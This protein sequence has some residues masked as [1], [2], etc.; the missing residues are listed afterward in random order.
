MMQTLDPPIVIETRPECDASV[1]WLHGLGADGNDFAPVVP[2]LGLAPDLAVRFVFPH[3]PRRPVT[4]NGGMVMRAWFDMIP[5]RTGFRENEDDLRTSMGFVD[6]LVEAERVRGVSP[7]RIVLAG[8]SQGALTALYTALYLPVELAGVLALSAWL[9]EGGELPVPPYALPVFL[10]HGSEDPL[11]PLTLGDRARTRL[12]ELGAEV[13]WHRYPMGH[14]VCPQ[15][16][17]DIGRW[18]NLRLRA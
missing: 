6:T 7:R 18:L 10:G 16:I 15:E 11:I 4:I 9:P 14:S 5:T 8:F 1:I 13:E 17:E 3:A 12:R 2:E